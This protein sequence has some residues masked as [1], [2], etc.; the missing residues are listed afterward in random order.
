MLLTQR[1]PVGVSIL[2]LLLIRVPFHNAWS[3]MSY[4]C[5]ACCHHS[6]ISVGPSVHLHACLKTPS[7]A[8]CQVLEECSL[9]TCDEIQRDRMR[10]TQPAMVD[11]P[12]VCMA[13]SKGV[14][15]ARISASQVRLSFA[16]LSA[17]WLIAHVGPQTWHASRAELHPSL[18]QLFSR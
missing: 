1:M 7:F 8:L 17:S 18:P 9:Y 13:T 15:S 5:L 16:V 12:G 4:V 14:G 6:K 3:A 11:V 10:K 2:S